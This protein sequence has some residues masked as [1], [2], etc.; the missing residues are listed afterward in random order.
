MI[1]DVLALLD[2]CGQRATAMTAAY[3]AGEGELPNPAACLGMPGFVVAAIKDV[4]NAEPQ[5]F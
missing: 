5:V 1:V 2:L 3:Q 4:L